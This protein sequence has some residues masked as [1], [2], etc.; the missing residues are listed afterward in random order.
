MTTNSKRIAIAAFVG[1]LSLYAVS[2]VS[3]VRQ[4]SQRLQNGQADLIELRQKLSQIQALSD[5]PSIAA[6]QIQAA[7]ELLNRIYTAI[8]DAGL[9]ERMLSTQSPSA[10][11][12]IDRSDYMLQSVSIKLN[13]ATVP[14]ITAFCDELED[15]STGSLVRDMKLTSPTR[16]GN[17]ELWDCQLILTQITFSPKSES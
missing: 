14:Q 6:L 7:D 5:K 10:P 3:E 16:Q 15:A 11:Q 12:R 2:A 13:R 17:R 8:A 1:L 9:P 4:K